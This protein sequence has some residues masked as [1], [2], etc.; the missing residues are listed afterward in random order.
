MKLFLSFIAAI[1]CVSLNA[2][3]LQVDVSAKSAILM[4]AETG[5]I[6]YE[7]N[8]H[9]PAYP[10]SITKVATAHY[11]LDVK[12][13]DLAKSVLVSS[14]SLRMKPPKRDWS[15]LPA[16]WLEMDGTKMGLMKG[17]EIPIE[18]LLYGMMLVSANDAANVLAESMSGSIPAF[19]S[20][21]NQ[22]LKSIG[23]LN[24]HFCNPHGLHHPE[25]ITTAYDM[26]LITK[27]ALRN[28]KF[29]EI[30]SKLTY[31]KP[32]TNKLPEETLRQHNHL[33]RPGRF[34]YPKAIG[35]KTGFTSQAQNTLVA[36]ARHEGRTLIA[37][38][39]GC[40][41][42]ENRY[43]DV[44]KLFETAFAERPVH[45]ILFSGQECFTRAIEGGTALLQ[46][47][48]AHEVAIDYFPAEETEP[49]AEIHWTLPRLPISKGS[50][51]AQ[52]RLLDANGHLLTEAPLLAKEEVSASWLFII[53]DGWHHIFH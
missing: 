1:L 31:N 45:R 43:V 24:T 25:H 53:K 6:L 16:H 10:A 37:V 26:C 42:R 41:K 40:E 20:E 21:L 19:V 46:A 47:V 35:V 3:P 52:L 28:P 30:V 11:V 14:E 33:L 12:K 23:C 2:K 15:S 34:F 49:K 44:K 48:L 5:A 4:N 32:H 50:Q 17:E 7:K 39:L 38:V 51:V 8:S 18:A 36:A 22:Y 29:R 9:A 27:N 13:A